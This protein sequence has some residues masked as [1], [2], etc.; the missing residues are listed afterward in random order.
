MERIFDLKFIVP[1][2]LVI[3]FVFIT[4]P[5]EYLS[6]I[7]SY[8]ILLNTIVILTFGFLIS[9]TAN[10]IVNISHKRD[11]LKECLEKKG[12][13]TKNESEREFISWK[14]ESQYSKEDNGIILYKS[15]KELDVILYKKM[16]NNTIINVSEIEKLFKEFCEEN[17]IEFLENKFEEFLKFLKIDFYDWVKGN[18]SQF[19]KQ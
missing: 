15:V 1:P 10:S 16:K 5:T 18:L 2:I 6:I 9:T 19:N 8:D 14:A 3:F 11:T 12:V 4:N 13:K 7:K 17:K